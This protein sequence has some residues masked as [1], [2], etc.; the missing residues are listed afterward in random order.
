MVTLSIG[1]TKTLA[2]TAAV[3]VLEFVTQRLNSADPTFTSDQLRFY[4]QNN[5]V[6]KASPSTTDRVLRDLRAK[7]KLDYIVLNRG[8][9]LYKAV[10]IGTTSAAPMTPIKEEWVVKYEVN[11]EWFN[12]WNPGL[13][14][15]IFDTE[16]AANQAIKRYGSKGMIYKAVRK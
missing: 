14:R 15:Q 8:L 7:G 12:S 4:V 5:I 3:A 13:Q 11:E 16:A 9:S 1:N 6:G 10:K 2:P